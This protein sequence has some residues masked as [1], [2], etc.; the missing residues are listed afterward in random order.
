MIRLPDTDFEKTRERVVL[1]AAIHAHA[2]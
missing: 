1:T 2:A